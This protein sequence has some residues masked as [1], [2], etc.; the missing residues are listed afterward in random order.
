MK[1][2][3]ITGVSGQDGQLLARLLLD[4]NYQVV[5]VSRAL[6][7]GPDLA[8]IAAHPNFTWVAADITSD[9]GISGLIRESQPHEVYHLAAHTTVATQVAEERA[10]LEA[11]IIGTEQLLRACHHEA[12]SS[13]FFFAGSSEMFGQPARVP[14]DEQTPLM[15]CSIYGI[16]KVTGFHL[17]R[18][19]RE[20]KNYFGSCGILYNHESPLR[21][22]HFVT[23][24]VTS[25]AARIKRGQAAK[26]ELG[27]LAAKR[28]WSCAREVV[29]AM[30]QMLQQPQPLDLILASG[31][32]HSIKEL[33]RI[34]FARVG[35]DYRDWVV[36]VSR[37]YRAEDRVLL[38]NPAR[39]AETIGWQP[40]RS[41]QEIIEEM[42]DHDLALEKNTT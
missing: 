41:F 33:C 31:R 25:H 36:S 14:Q 26:L 21:G 38:G 5:G 1:R 2:A 15:P 3:V 9:T 19:F 27:N 30:W 24:K 35:L 4:K 11:N 29:T 16:S 37:Y 28:D 18:Y 40:Q 32:R 12:P 13:R 20:T 6:H 22:K 10:M 7:P 23:R 39:A 17:L 8:P 42:V 34:A